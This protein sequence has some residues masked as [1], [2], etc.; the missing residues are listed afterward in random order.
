MPSRNNKEKRSRTFDRIDQET[1]YE[2]KYGDTL[3]A[4]NLDFLP[5]DL[6]EKVY[7]TFDRYFGFGLLSQ[8]AYKGEELPSFPNGVATLNSDEVGDFLGQFTAWYAFTADKKK[9][10]VVAMNVVSN[11][12]DIIFR[13]ELATMTTKANL[14]IKKAAA[15][16][17]EDYLI[18]EE[19]VQEVG[20]LMDMLDI[21]LNKLDKSIASLSREISRRERFSGI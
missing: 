3:K 16:V 4:I 10:L 11:E 2:V 17:T 21:E 7:R 12:L 20:N 1:E 19:Y 5:D 13:K 9:Y 14:E 15:R 18:V 8:A 6:R